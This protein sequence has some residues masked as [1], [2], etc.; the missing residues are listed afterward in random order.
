MKHT[1]IV[2]SLHDLIAKCSCD[3]WHMVSTTTSRDTDEEI[4]KTVRANFK[5]HQVVVRGIE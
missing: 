3:G 1:L 2:E 4:R 5:L